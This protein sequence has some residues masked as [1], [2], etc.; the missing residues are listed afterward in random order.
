MKVHSYRFA[1]LPDEMRWPIDLVRVI[2]TEVP[3]G[4]LLSEVLELAEVEAKALCKKTEIARLPLEENAPEI[5]RAVRILTSAV[6]V[7]WIVA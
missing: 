1:T 7:T 4:T 6:E 2:I 5:P 3:E